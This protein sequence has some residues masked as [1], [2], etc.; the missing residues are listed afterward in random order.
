MGLSLLGLGISS[1]LAFASFRGEV[2][3]CGSAEGCAL[4][5]RSSYAGLWGLPLAFWGALLYLL[6]A[7]LPLVRGDRSSPAAWEPGASMA[8]AL[9]GM[10]YSAY[11]T[12][13]ELFV[14]YAVCWWCVAS[15]LVFAVLAALTSWRAWG[16]LS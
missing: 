5:Q 1:Y 7:S 4:V 16:A 13:V 14:L 11:L 10:G 12:W 3:F 6:L 9:G 15:A 2:P 8:L